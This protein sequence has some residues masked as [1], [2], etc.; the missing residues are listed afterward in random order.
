MGRVTRRSRL[1][2]LVAVVVAVLAVGAVWIYVK[3]QQAADALANARAGV[4]WCARTWPPGDRQPPLNSLAVV[5]GDTARAADATSDPVFTVA[6]SIPVIG[7]TPAAVSDVADAADALAQDVLPDLVEAGTALSP[8][9]LRDRGR[10][11]QP[12][13]VRARRLPRWS[14]R[15]RPW[16]SITADVAGIETGGTPSAGTGRR[17]RAAG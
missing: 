5:Q 14:L 2:L 16:R 15:R 17:E 13:G 6:S 10:P 11:A 8:D 12:R 1:L 4:T 3:G 9:A 7:A